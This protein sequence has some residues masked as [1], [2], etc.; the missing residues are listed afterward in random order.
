M[1]RINKFTKEKKE[2]KSE[3]QSM[4]FDSKSLVDKDSK[5]GFKTE[6]ED[7][8]DVH[9]KFK[10]EMDKIEKFE[11]FIN[12]H[13]DNIENIETHWDVEH[14]VEIDGDD[15]DDDNE[16]DAEYEEEEGCGCCDS[17]TGQP[18]CSCCDDC[19]CDEIDVQLVPASQFVNN[20]MSESLKYHIQNN[21]PVT[22]NIFRPGS[23]A[24][25]SVIK[26]TR[27]HFDDKKISLCELDKEIFE[28]TEIGKFA[29]FKG[30]LVALDLPMENH[31]ELNEAEY[32]G[33]EVRLNYPMRGGTKKYYVY[34]K[35]PKTGKVKK[36]AFGDVHG[37]LTAKVSNP[38]ARKSFAA[39]HKCSTKKDKTKAGYWACRINKYGHL[40]G[41]KTY[42][43]YW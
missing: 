27:Q 8:E 17:C 18:G 5:P 25:Y 38:E 6:V 2:E 29:Y 19:E 13:I 42:P 3:P 24:F 22:E 30:E 26:E 32:K 14:E 16:F 1:K 37:G 43:G 36:I 7:T 23:D 21:V 35:N 39:R 31:I 10:Q 4:G 41:G 40:W 33:K 9:K 34:V 28:S 15:E 20:V 12:I 11:T